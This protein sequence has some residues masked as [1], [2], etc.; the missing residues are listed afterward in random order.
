VPTIVVPASAFITVPTGT[1]S[2]TGVVATQSMGLITEVGSMVLTGVV[3]TVTETIV[4]E[5]DTTSLWHRRY[6]RIARR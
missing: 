4:S 1:C 6:R 5:G 3:P 2:V